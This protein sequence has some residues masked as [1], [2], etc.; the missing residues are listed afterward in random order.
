MTDLAAVYSS[1]D[2]THVPDWMPRPNEAI[3]VSA[4]DASLRSDGLREGTIR[5]TLASGMA[6]T[7]EWLR[8]ALAAAGLEATESGTSYASESRYRR[9]EVETEQLSPEQTRITLHYR[10]TDHSDACPC[11]ICHETAPDSK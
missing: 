6:E 5:Y 10:S 11:S 4:E 7:G 3:S 8:Q 1:L 9:C 2:F